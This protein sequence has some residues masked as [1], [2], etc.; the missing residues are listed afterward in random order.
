MVLGGFFA[1][2]L[3]PLKP[4]EC[5][6]FLFYVCATTWGGGVGGG[7]TSGLKIALAGEPRRAGGALEPGQFSCEHRPSRGCPQAE[8]GAGT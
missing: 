7:G 6:D 1:F 3:S 2:N 5:W 4:E 8:V